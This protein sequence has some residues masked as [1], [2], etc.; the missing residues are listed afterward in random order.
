[1]AQRLDELNLKRRDIEADHVVDANHLIETNI[2][3]EMKG[4]VIHDPT[5]HPGVVGILASRI[6]EK[7]NRPVICMTDTEEAGERREEL[8]ALQARKA[9]ADEIKAARAALGECYIKGSSRSIKGVH[10]KHVLDEIASHHPDILDKA[11][12]GGHAMAAGLGVKEKN[13]LRFIELFNEVISHQVTEDQLLGSIEVDIKDVEPQY[14]TMQTAQELQDLGPWGQLFP[15]PVFHGK[16]KMVSHK[17]V[18]EKHLK[19]TLSLVGHPQDKFEAIAFGCVQNQ[20]LPVGETFDASFSLDI[21]SF[22]GK[23]TLQLKINALQDPV[24]EQRKALL[25]DQV[26]ATERENERKA[27][28]RKQR[29]ENAYAVL[30]TPD[31]VEPVEAKIKGLKNTKRDDPV[32][33][34]REDMQD[35]LRRM[36]QKNATVDDSSPSP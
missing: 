29:V 16:F 3:I 21:N 11:K 8:A 27:Q 17:I 6:K 7:L 25:K 30:E 24:L 19:M 32:E 9:P 33:R 14:L 1:M 13:L 4:V 15:D 34:L 28:E 5:W 23:D 20:E 26:A 22:R 12:F 10:L 36:K 18:G 35:V 31:G 2:L